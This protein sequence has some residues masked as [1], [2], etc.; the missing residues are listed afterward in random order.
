MITITIKTASLI[1]D[2]KVKSHMNTARIK[3]PEDRYAV[4]AAEENEGEVLESLQEAWRMLKGI[5]RPFLDV[6]ADS[7]GNDVFDT[8]TTDKSLV[9]D[10]TVRRTSN[11]AEALSQAIHTFLVNGTLRR[12]YTTAAMADLA[13]LYASGETASRDEIVNLLYRKMEPVYD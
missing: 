5:C 13:S 3:D 1:S 12:F 2:I 4:R 7:T 9:F 10:V 6:T 8:S 11:I